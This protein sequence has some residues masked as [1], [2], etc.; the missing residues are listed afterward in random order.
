MIILV[1]LN[2]PSGCCVESGLEGHETLSRKATWQVPAG[3]CPGGLDQGGGSGHRAR[4]MEPRSVRE[5]TKGAVMEWS[6]SQLMP[7]ILGD[8]TTVTEWCEGS[9]GLDLD[10]MTSCTCG[11]SSEACGEISVKNT[12]L[13]ILET[14]GVG[15]VTQESQGQEQ[16]RETPQG[17]RGKEAL[18]KD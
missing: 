17:M 2:D 4:R 16:S 8:G 6:G 12:D 14:T 11:M 3:Q 7:S 15:D 1:L 10:T 5:S 18:K 9:L 13:G